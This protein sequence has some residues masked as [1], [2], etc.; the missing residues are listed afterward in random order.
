MQNNLVNVTTTDQQIVDSMNIAGMISTVEAKDQSDPK[1][2]V[3]WIRQLL[4]V[5]IKKDQEITYSYIANLS[6]M[7]YVKFPKW[8]F[9]PNT[10]QYVAEQSKFF[11]TY[12][13]LCELLPQAIDIVRKRQIHARNNTTYQKEPDFN[14]L[15][16]EA[17]GWVNI[18]YN[19][20][21]R[22]WREGEE[23]QD[24]D[25][26][27]TE[28]REKKYTSLMLK[29]NPEAYEY[30]FP[31]EWKAQLRTP[32]VI[33]AEKKGNWESDTGVLNTINE[34]EQIENIT[35]KR[36]II[37][38]FKNAIRVHAPEWS[39]LVEQQYPGSYAPEKEE[40]KKKQGY[41]A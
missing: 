5:T 4:D 14:Q 32:E 10:L 27:E 11:P 16:D 40:K 23:Q 21:F 24:P 39:E 17:K 35:T 28:K 2:I 38:G 37:F 18:Y 36:I 30:L 25:I 6:L 20:S 41:F 29:I 3:N 31:R 33:Q 13:E 1:R 19:K 8:A 7:L 15:S 22:H 34:I 9:S 26:Q 12:N